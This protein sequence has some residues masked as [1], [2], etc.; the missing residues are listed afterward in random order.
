MSLTLTSSRKVLAK[1]RIR[2][3]QKQTEA[4]RTIQ[5]LVE[6]NRRLQKQKENGGTIRK[7]AEGNRTMQ[8]LLE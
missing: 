7:L 1:E 6:G 5:A 8:K 4:G 3:R 2:T